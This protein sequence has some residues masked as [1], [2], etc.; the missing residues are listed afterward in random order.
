MKI[1][2]LNK[3]FTLI[4]LLLV[5]AVIAILAS[6]LLPSL[7]KSRE[8]VWSTVCMDN[9]K[10]CG[11]ATLMY[12]GDFG[13][14][15]QLTGPNKPWECFLYD[16]GYIRN[17]NTFLC[18]IQSPRKY[19]NQFNVY[20]ATQTSTYISNPEPG[21]VINFYAIQNPSTY[22]HLADSVTVV[23]SS[24]FPNQ[25]YVNDNPD[26]RIHLRHPGNI[27]NT[28]FADGHTEGC[29]KE[30]LRDCGK[31]NLYSKNYNEITF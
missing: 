22:I 15:V 19:M 1:R 20:G 25:I 17:Q 21:K 13:G 8:V 3:R 14:K 10:Q 9:L 7:Q 12:A 24:N 18:P 5:I 31:T 2:Q 4:E 29:K 27:A 28:L 16:G 11:T 23:T 30:R 6:M 26:T